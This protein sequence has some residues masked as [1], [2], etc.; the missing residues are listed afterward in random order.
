MNKKVSVLIGKRYISNDKCFCVLNIVIGER[1]L[2][3][4]SRIP[5]RKKFTKNIFSKILKFVK[6]VSIFETSKDSIL[7]S[8]LLNV[9]CSPKLNS[10]G[11]VQLISNSTINPNIILNNTTVLES[12]KL[13]KLKLI[14]NSIIPNKKEKI[15]VVIDDVIKYLKSE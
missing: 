10:P 14:K 5:Y 1:F 11:S 8:L 6:E 2:L 9:Q 3:E 13:L 4:F 7:Y 15:R 12:L